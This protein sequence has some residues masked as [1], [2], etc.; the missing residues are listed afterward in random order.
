[1][2]GGGGGCRE[3]GCVV[4]EERECEGVVVIWICERDGE[5]WKGI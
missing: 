1:M 2:G 4:R 3:Q 5:G